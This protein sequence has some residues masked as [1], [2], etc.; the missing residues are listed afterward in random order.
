MQGGD[1]KKVFYKGVF[2]N[3]P[4]LQGGINY[5][6][7]TFIGEGFVGVCLEWGVLKSTCFLVNVYA[8]C[9]LPSKRRLWQ[10]I[11]MSKLGFGNGKWCVIGDFNAVLYPEERRD[12]SAETFSNL[13]MRGF[14]SFLEDVDL[15]DLPILG[16]RFTWYHANGVA[17]SRIDRGWVSPEWL[18]E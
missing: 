15:I 12:L 7:L 6:T 10:N 8:K 9:D 5:L 3:R 11:S 16:R 17:M 4:I 2:Q 13:E 1:L 14:R 18:Q